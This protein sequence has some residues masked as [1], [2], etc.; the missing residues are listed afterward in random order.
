MVNKDDVWTIV[1]AGMGGK[2]LLAELGINGFRL[3]THDKNEAQVAGIRAAGGIHVDGRAK[4]FGP[5]ELATTNLAQPVDGARIIIVSTNGDDHPQVARDLA[6][7]LRDGQIVILCMGHFGGT[8]VL[9]K[10]LDDAGCTAKVQLAEMDGYPYMMTVRGPDRVEMTTYKERYQLVALPASHSA[11]VVNDIGFAFPGLVP[12]PNL[13]Q[14]G[15]ADLGGI[16]HACALITNVGHAENGQPYNFYA[17]NMT[18]SVCNLLEAVDRERLAVAKAYGV[19]LPDA[20]TWLEITYNRKERS[21]HWSLQANAVTHYKFSPAPDSLTHRFL[22]T[23][24]GSV[25]VAWSSLAKVAGVPTPLIDSVIHIA[26]GLSQRNFFDEGRNLK[27][28]G[29]EGRDVAGIV[30]LVTQ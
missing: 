7:H 28:L 27:N 14:T 13:L 3:R 15:F 2:G 26:G 29:L 20:R 30:Q 23:D 21:L 22:V 4:T 17:A 11:A 16:F 19:E 12:G 24:V 9:R 6:P 25:L 8:L 18:P 1:G 5:V 10:A